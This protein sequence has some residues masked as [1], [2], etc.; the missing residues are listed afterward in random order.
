MS[1]CFRAQ[2]TKAEVAKREKIIIKYIASLIKDIQL[3]PGIMPY[4]LEYGIIDWAW[5]LRF[6]KGNQPF[7]G[8]KY[9]SRDAYNAV[10]DGERIEFRRDHSFPKKRLKEML[11]NFKQ[12]RSYIC[13]TV[14][15]NLWRNMCHYKR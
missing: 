14:N 8:Y 2:Y 4:F 3:T 9:Y 5:P 15:G 6:V 7:K 12:S 13:Q 1:H 11:Y 10:V